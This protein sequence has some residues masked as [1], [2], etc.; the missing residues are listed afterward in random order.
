MRAFYGGSDRLIGHN[1]YFLELL[2][3]M[4]SVY[5]KLRKQVRSFW[6]PFLFA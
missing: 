2:L 5:D 1:S 4:L 3:Y 6:V